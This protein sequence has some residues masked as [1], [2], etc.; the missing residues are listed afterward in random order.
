MLDRASYQSFAKK[1]F[2]DFFHTPPEREDVWQYCIRATSGTTGQEPISIISHYPSGAVKRFAKV[3]A[4]LLCLG[5]TGAR[6]A[7]TIQARHGMNTGRVLALDSADLSPDLGS[8]IFEFEPDSI[9]G[10]VS[11]VVR[12]AEHM[13]PVTAGRI[14]LLSIGG[15]CLTAATEEFLQTIF[16]NA[17][18]TMRYIAAEVGRISQASCQYQQ[19]NQYHPDV[20][21]V[22]EI[23][24]PDETGAGDILVSKHIYGND[25][26]QYKTGDIGRLRTEVC[27]C[28]ATETLELLGRGGF[29]YVKIVGAH[30]VRDECDRVAKKLRLYDDYH[31]EVSDSLVSG[32]LKGKLVLKVSRNRSPFSDSELSEIG[33]AF[34][35]EVYLTPTQSLENLVSQGI[36]E[37]L[38]VDNLD[39]KSQTHKEIKIARKYV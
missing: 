30:V 26:V 36:F 4:P 35:Q 15:E 29:D 9:F 5:A 33:R 39:E 38:A 6:L 21:V 34:S 28:G 31:I 18:I 14:R 12:V 32:K 7:Y 2:E 8:H 25:I 23:G 10:F 3:H 17:S 1:T 27:Q 19:R 16:P 13:D 20:G 22:L 11:F 24:S 37:P